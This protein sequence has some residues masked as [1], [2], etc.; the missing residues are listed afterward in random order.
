MGEL[1][2]AVMDVLWDRGEPVAVRE[3]VRALAGR[4][5]AYTTVM[6]VLNRLAKKGFVRREPGEGRAFDYAPVAGR[7]QYV[8]RLMLDALELAG[9]RGTALAHFARSVSE[10]EAEALSQALDER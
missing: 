1:E 9:D 5:L 10:P 7:E 6:T 2:R 8:A 4:D 3:V